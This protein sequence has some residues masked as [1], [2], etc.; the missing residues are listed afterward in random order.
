MRAENW[1]EQRAEPGGMNEIE[2]FYGLI[3]NTMD[4][5]RI[6]QLCREGRLQRVRRRLHERE[7]RLIRSGSV[8]VFNEDESGIRRWTDGRLWSPS[9]ILGNFLI[10][11][12]L[13]KKGANRQAG[14]GSK[15]TRK[16][17]ALTYEEHLAGLELMSPPI[18][19][20]SELAAAITASIKRSA[21]NSQP[22]IDPRQLGE[23]LP[24]AYLLS[25]QECD[26][27]PTS[28]ENLRLLKSKKLINNHKGRYVFKQEGLIKKTVSIQMDG[29]ACHLIAY[30]SLDDFCKG[31]LQLNE[32]LLA[33]DLICSDLE[34][35]KSQ[36]ESANQQL[37]FNTALMEQ[38]R[39]VV[40]PLDLMLQQNFRKPAALLATA[41]NLTNP[42]APND[43]RAE[44]GDKLLTALE[45]G[46]IN[47]SDL[48]NNNHHHHN[49]ASPPQP[50]KGKTAKEYYPSGGII[51]GGIESNPYYTS[52]DMISQP[53]PR[54]HSMHLPVGQTM[55]SVIVDDPG[56]YD[57]SPSAFL[58]EVSVD[59]EPQL[60]EI[61]EPFYFPQKPSPT[62]TEA[63]TDEFFAIM[64]GS[65]VDDSAAEEEPS[66]L[67]D[68]YD[69]SVPLIMNGEAED[70]QPAL[71]G[72]DV[73]LSSIINY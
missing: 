68:Y 71:K 57:A 73:L 19:P 3:E 46:A 42:D 6:F 44:D 66:A 69:A 28:D 18:S 4:A 9:R 55:A 20:D 7:R 31:H 59:S 67:L 11:R 43:K 41:T 2:T 64:T 26:L 21:A 62:I 56:I 5:L 16:R 15:F 48:A 32:L 45:I 34:L 52:N 49:H 14:K 70:S 63:N 25:E 30:Y 8:F 36:D 39:R 12:E 35:R 1:K 29:H 10:Y 50:K 23:A 72:S 40:V 54:R 60:I 51:F 53:R 47:P 27:D 13:E 24:A 61:E 22:F 17:P 65:T 58:Q 38:M 37:P 33:D